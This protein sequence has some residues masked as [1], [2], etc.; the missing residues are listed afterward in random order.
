MDLSCG[1]FYKTIDEAKTAIK[2]YSK[3]HYCIH[4]IRPRRIKTILFVGNRPRRIKKNVFVGNRPR[5]KKKLN[6]SGFP[7]NNDD[8]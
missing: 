2:Q 7:T 8:H 1:K 4:V 3:E 5:R 6:L